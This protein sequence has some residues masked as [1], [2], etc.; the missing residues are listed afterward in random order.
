MA[1]RSD[2]QAEAGFEQHEPEASPPLSVD[3][4]R[5]FREQHRCN[6]FVVNNNKIIVNNR[7][8]HQMPTQQTII[9][10]PRPP[11][12]APTR[13]ISD[14]RLNE[15]VA[16]PAR[17]ARALRRW[18][19]ITSDKE[20]L[21]IISKGLRFEF[22]SDRRPPAR[23]RP[24][25]FNSSKP[26]VMKALV[27][28]LNDWL[29]QGVIEP[30]TRGD[31]LYTL[32]FPVRKADG[33]LRFV[34]D[35]RALNETLRYRRFKMEGI[36]TVRRVVRK[37]DWLSSIDLKDAF[38][39]VPINR[40]HRRYLAFRANDRNWQF[41]AMIFGTSS[42][43]R[44]FTRLMRPL[45]GYLHRLGIRSTMYMDDLLLASS[46]QTEALRA[47]KVARELIES[48][49]LTINYDKSVFLPTQRL[50]HLGLVW[51]AAQNKVFAPVQKLRALAR[52]ARNT[53]ADGEG[54]KPI[55]I[56]TL[57]KISGIVTALMPAMRIATLRR[58]SLER[59]VTFGLRGSRGDWDSS[60]A[61][62]RSAIDDLRF[63]ASSAPLRHNGAPINEP[64]PDATI[65]TDASG[66]GW[67]ATIE[68]HNT[69]PN[70]DSLY[71]LP[72]RTISICGR[73]RADESARS[74]NWREAEGM[75]LALHAFRS[76]WSKL[77]S[78]RLR[79]DNS[80][81]VSILRRGGSRHRHLGQVLDASMRQLEHHRVNLLVEHIAGTD[82]VVADQL[83]RAGLSDTDRND[84]SLSP[85]AFARICRRYGRP[86]IDWFAT[87]RNA[88][89]S[90]FATRR[91]HRRA[92][93]IDAMRCNWRNEFGIFVPPFN[94]LE[95]VIHRLH[96][97]GAGSPRRPMGILVVPHWPSRPWY[98]T[99]MESL[100]IERPLSLGT[101]A[102]ATGSPQ[103]MRSS[104]QPP[105]LAFLI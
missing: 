103:P 46:S 84:W 102:I 62:S 3:D 92:T 90:R 12:N 98:G 16:L 99:L 68:F 15:R 77:R 33:R 60:V 80:T 22:R 54:G 32:L 37:G 44:T 40:A 93:Y 82:N 36:P 11:G 83:S 45:L 97:Q 86:T 14:R 34:L 38:L 21:E 95:Q 89:C 94:L 9:Q 75:R 100:A 73:F 58:H 59:L 39:H 31:A 64:E 49:G 55:P 35:S 17:L 61:L 27:D 96:V 66:V 101:S 29:E 48:L 2:R 104:R 8:S 53:L 41:R 50:T 71:P 26:E 42:A 20:L 23:R 51:D 1:S 52:T 5:L 69:Q 43:P 74:S 67:G 6:T 28:Q 76:R 57:A 79:S 63:W 78:L 18:R 70:D 91:P 19:S 47:A 30:C 13:R 24:P 10:Q 25:V 105:M 81:V 4:T 85:T 7:H 72:N 88:L 56:R 65:T 87:H